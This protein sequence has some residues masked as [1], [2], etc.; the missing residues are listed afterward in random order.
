VGDAKF[1]NRDDWGDCKPTP[2]LLPRKFIA[3]EVRRTHYRVAENA[4][5]YMLV[6]GQARALADVNVVSG[7]GDIAVR[8]YSLSDNGS[9][10]G[11]LQYLA[12]TD[13][14]GTRLVRQTP[15]G[16]KPFVRTDTVGP[17]DYLATFPRRL[18][19]PAVFPLSAVTYQLW[20][21]PEI[22]GAT[23]G[24]TVPGGKV[25]AG[26]TWGYRFLFSCFTSPPGELNE[27]PERIRTLY[28][29]A[30]KPG[31]TVAVKQG[32][33][34]GT[35]YELRLKAVEGAAQVELGQADLPGSLP[36][37]VEGLNDRW[38][39]VIAEAAADPRFIAAFEGRG[40]T[41]TDLR[42]GAKSLFVGHPVRCG[43]DRLFLNLVSWSADRA[44]V[45]VHNP[46]EAVLTAWVATSPACR[47]VPSAKT[48]VTV[49]PGASV[50]V[51]LT[52][53]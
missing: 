7:P 1:S 13:S 41:V 50:M 20:G 49:G 33:L 27:T 6:E 8:L 40:Y 37:V 22:F 26:D 15:E 23:F 48:N 11:E 45:E 44:V 21:A 28:G 52:K 14:D 2:T 43:D 12:C 29:L 31:Y 5:G 32:A 9:K 4:P 42:Q 35:A 3:N 51:T 10:G 39:A 30:G 34:L 53:P 24:A 47:F 19:A 46:T 36:I 17:G 18:G 16:A 38:S 25:H